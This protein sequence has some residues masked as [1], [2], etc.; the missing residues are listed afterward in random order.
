MSDQLSAK[1]KSLINKWYQLACLNEMLAELEHHMTNGTVDRTPFKKIMTMDYLE[2][3]GNQIGSCMSELVVVSQLVVQQGLTQYLDK[4][5]N[6]LILALLSKEDNN[7]V[8][9]QQEQVL[10]PNTRIH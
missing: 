3:V 10:P 2:M 5:D 6:K 7:S 1:D 4:E 8:I 9:E